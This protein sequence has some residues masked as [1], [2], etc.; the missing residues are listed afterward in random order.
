MRKLL[1]FTFLAVMLTSVALTSNAQWHCLYATWDNSANGTGQ[2]VLGVGVIH[3]DM[4][5]ALVTVRDA[6]S[7]LIP[8]VNADSGSGRK[9][10][11]GYGSAATS[12]IYQTWTDGGFDQV[13]SKNNFAIKAMP[14]SL[15][16]VASNDV[17]HNV[18][19]FKYTA[20]TIT[21]ADP[22]PRQ[23]TGTNSIW[24]IDVDNNGYVYVCNDTTTGQTA[25]LKVYKPIKQWTVGGHAD[26]PQT[27]INL[28]DGVYKGIAVTPNGNAIFIADYANK[29]IIKYTGSPAAGYTLAAGFNFTMGPQDTISGTPPKGT[30]PIGLA[31]LPSKN[32]V[33]VACDSL[34]KPTG[35]V[36]YAYGR[37]YLLN[38]NTGAKISTDT[39][40]STINQAAWAY[41]VTGSYSSRGDGDIPGN[42][43]G[44]TSTYDVKFDEKGN[45][46]SQSQYGWTV[47]KWAYNGTLPSFTTG[48]EQSGTEIPAGYTL[49]QNYPNPFNPTSTVDFT[50]PQAGFVSL[51]V[52]DV[53]GREVMTLVNEEK[54][55]GSFRATIDASTM[56]S[57]TYFYT[58][59]AG[60]FVSTKKM[61]LLK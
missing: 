50:M 52:Y 27:T 19:V 35:G 37:I 3:E 20:D 17:D 45:V 25:D 2:Q 48:V 36:N 1:R 6:R 21:V 16:Y 28:P 41:S 14:D 61:V 59:R 9:Y 33:A 7:F 8:Y 49:S 15:I 26:A 29:K 47:E 53:L 56:T 60:N 10:F 4:F 40:M 34:F 5:V 39:S 13:I 22:F 46:Y 24:G 55:A 32:I 51:K 30:G 58:L 54:P 38:G 43:S 42:I 18:L 57:G 12:G 23:Q 11:Y 44:Y 31:Y